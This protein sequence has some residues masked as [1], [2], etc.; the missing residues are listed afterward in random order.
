[1]WS[2]GLKESTLEKS[3]EEAAEIAAK[4]CSF[5]EFLEKRNSRQQLGNCARHSE[6]RQWPIIS[7]KLKGKAQVNFA[8]RLE[9]FD[10]DMPTIFQRIDPSGL[11]L[12][13]Y[14]RLRFGILNDS[15]H[16]AYTEHY[17]FA[18]GPTK[19]GR[20]ASTPSKFCVQRGRRSGDSDAA[21]DAQ[22]D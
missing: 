17:Q 22:H 7:W 1:M 11:L 14:Q 2:Y 13:T 10:R 12:R 19:R 4:Y 8:G 20:A 15:N 18:K 3:T 16:T 5:S 21:V 9:R 6:S